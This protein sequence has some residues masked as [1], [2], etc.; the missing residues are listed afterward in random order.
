MK[1]LRRRRQR[2]TEMHEDQE[3]WA[4]EALVGEAFQRNLISEKGE[5]RKKLEFLLVKVII[6][7][8]F[9]SHETSI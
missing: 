7:Y 9:W 2:Q 3:L 4:R 5:V 6:E 8:L 1:I